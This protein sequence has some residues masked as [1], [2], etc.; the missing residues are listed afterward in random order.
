M[1]TVLALSSAVTGPS[2]QGGLV[3][4][5]ISDDLSQLQIL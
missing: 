4:A 5:L 2:G 3:W 1:Q